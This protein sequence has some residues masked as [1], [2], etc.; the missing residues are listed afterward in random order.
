MFILD[1]FGERVVLM[2]IWVVKS[3][4]FTGYFKVLR[5]DFWI[6]FYSCFLIRSVFFLVS[7]GKYLFFN[8][9]GDFRVNFYDFGECEN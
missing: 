2:L 3:I 9:F 7:S 6:D 8:G 1:R 4:N 5:C